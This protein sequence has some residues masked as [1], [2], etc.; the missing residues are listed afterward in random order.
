M[1]LFFCKLSWFINNSF[2]N[3]HTPQSGHCLLQYP[4]TLHYFSETL[5]GEI[6]NILPYSD[7][8]DDRVLLSSA[9]RFK[10]LRNKLKFSLQKNVHNMN[11]SR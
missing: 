1:A 7:L 4:Y 9:D 11:E 6:S 8:S 3:Y 10:I 5:Q 2:F